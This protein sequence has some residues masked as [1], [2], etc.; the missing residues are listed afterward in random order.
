MAHTFKQALELYNQ[1]KLQQAELILDELLKDGNNGIDTLYLHGIID[2][3]L[4]KIALALEY[5]HKTSEKS[6][7]HAESHYNMGLCYAY[8]EKTEEAVTHYKKALEL[9]PRHANSMNNLGAIYFDRKELDKA[10]ELYLKALACQPNNNN[11]MSNLGNVLFAKNKTE[12]ALACYWSAVTMEPGEDVV[13]N[14]ASA[15]N[16]IGFVHLEDRKINDSF[17]FFDKAIEVDPTYTEAYFN[18]ARGYLLTGDFENG[19]INYEYRIK[20]KEF[21]K[22][23]FLKPRLTEQDVNGK[24]IYV[25]TEQ[26]LGDTIQ[27]IRYLPLLKQKGAKIIFECNKKIVPMFADYK[28]FDVITEQISDDEPK[29]EY[30]YHI[31]LL[32]LPSYFNT[33]LSNIPGGVPYVFAKKEL[34]E[35]W[36][37]IINKDKN[38][39]I[40]IVWAGNPGHI[41]DKDRSCK[42][43]D[44]LPVFSIQGATVYII[45]KGDAKFQARDIL[46][47]YVNMNDYNFDEKEPFFDTAAIMENL[48]LIITVDTSIAHLAGAMNRP[49]WVLLS[50]IPDWRWMLDRSDTPWYPS[51]RLYRQEKAGDW[52]PVFATIKTE[53]EKLIAY[54]TSVYKE[55]I[56]FFKE[57]K[58]N[59]QPKEKERIY[60]GLSSGENF[61]WGVCS[62]YLKKEL[63]KRV[64]VIN[65]DENKNIADTGHAEGAV[66]HALTDLNF[67]SMYNVRGTKN[68]G[69]TFFENELNSNSVENAKKY[70]KIFAGS[71]WC[72][73][74]MTEKGINNSDVLIQGIDPELFYP[75][76]NEP[77]SNLFVVFSGGKFELRKG[78]DLV[79]SAIKILQQK[80]SDIVLI[81]AWYN[82]WPA[83]LNTMA[84]SNYIKFQLSGKTW[85]D[86]MRYICAINDIDGEKIFTLPLTPNN[87]TRELY[88]KTSIGLFPNRCEGGTNL[89]LMEYMACGKPVIASYNSG[90]KDILNEENSYPL[91]SMKELKINDGSGNLVCDWQEPNLDEIVAFLEYAYSHRDEIKQTGKKAGKDMAEL[92]WAKSASTL[93][94]RITL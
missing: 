1:N 35:Y 58:A 80:Y 72:K 73:D 2:F 3:K 26:G 36:S 82:M 24:T 92:T 65:I 76:D 84:A 34:V 64:D 9:N 63:S 40:G 52:S 56:Q 43:G 93:L 48:D 71:T 23:K 67:Y 38:F 18:K 29:Y 81:N 88:K 31:P 39:K 50:Y 27:F 83:S 70:D 15:Y 13:F 55:P 33:N 62:N 79:L 53:I 87:K 68:Y 42:L 20:R 8:L 28:G 22:R 59:I 32:S 16:N 17:K 14:K 86:Q 77:E 44:F 90:H 10:E 60:L 41:R 74:K 30:D 85:L 54:K 37:Q 12:D 21:G 61:G 45:Q 11:A 6:P 49:V 75:I 57:E 89:V 51:M 47:P 91:K 19:W 4:S 66:F 7:Q 78:Q 25:Y 46:Y 94:E 5:F 69:Y